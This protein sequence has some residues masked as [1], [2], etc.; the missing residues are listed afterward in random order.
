MLTNGIKLAQK[1][2]RHL[3]MKYLNIYYLKFI[4]Y[5]KNIFLELFN[6]KILSNKNGSYL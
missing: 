5:F 6:I 1:T 4:I 2:Y 3:F